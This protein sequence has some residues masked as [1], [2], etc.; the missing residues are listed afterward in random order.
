MPF[1]KIK[2]I[3][4]TTDFLPPLWPA[5]GYRRR[6][7]LCRNMKNGAAVA[8]IGVVNF[9][10]SAKGGGSGGAIKM[11]S[12]LR[13]R[14]RQR[15]NPL[16]R[17]QHP[18]GACSRRLAPVVPGL[19]PRDL[20]DVQRRLL[21]GRRG[22]SGAKSLSRPVEGSPGPGTMKLSAHRTGLMLSNSWMTPLSG[23]CVENAAYRRRACKRLRCTR[24]SCIGLASCSSGKGPCAMALSSF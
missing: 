24:R 21:F 4:V 17:C 2:S 18:L 19:I 13:P 22:R 11:I 14:L 12:R 8:A 7:S 10:L 15:C 5:A 16:P 20:L 6:P 9:C 1:L 23:T 3:Q